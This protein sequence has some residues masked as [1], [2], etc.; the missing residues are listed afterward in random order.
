MEHTLSIVTTVLQAAFIVSYIL[1]V[2]T[3][4][5][6]LDAM[7]MKLTMLELKL[8]RLQLERK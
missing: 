4:G 8:Q 1:Y 5:R 2:W 3:T 7:T 6:R